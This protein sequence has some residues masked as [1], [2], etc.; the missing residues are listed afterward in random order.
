M[1]SCCWLRRSTTPYGML[2]TPTTRN[3]L[4]LVR[5]L[6]TNGGTTSSPTTSMVA[7]RQQQQQQQRQR[8][9]ATSA[10]PYI[11]RA[12]EGHASLIISKSA[13]TVR[14]LSTTTTSAV[15]RF[16]LGW[17]WRQVKVPKGK[18]KRHTVKEVDTQRGRQRTRQRERERDACVLHPR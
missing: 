5:R 10:I 8:F 14:G 12:A 15:E 17:L 1:S 4:L 6:H 18:D 16:T 11:R 2:S 13:T 9:S 7:W 3:R